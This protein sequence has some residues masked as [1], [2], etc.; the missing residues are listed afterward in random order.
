MTREHAPID[1]SAM[2]EMVR[3]VD[4]VARTRRPRVLR[5]GTKAVAVLTPAATDDTADDA[6]LA[7]LERRRRQG[8]SVTDETA[9]IFKRYV[10]QPPLTLAEERDAFEQALADEALERSGG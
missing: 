4:E 5:H 9:G 1:I 10:T 7:E 3:L 2:P 8:L 6:V